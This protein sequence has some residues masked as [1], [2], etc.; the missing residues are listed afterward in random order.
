[1]TLKVAI[2][3][4]KQKKRMLKNDELGMYCQTSKSLIYWLIS[5]QKT[6]SG[7][8]FVLEQMLKSTDWELES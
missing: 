8:I 3:M 7:S 5:D 4:A 2:Q 6:N 1:M